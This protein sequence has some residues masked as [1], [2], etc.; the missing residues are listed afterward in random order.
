MVV[1]EGITDICLFQSSFVKVV[2]TPVDE[3][4]Y[5]YETAM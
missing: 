3:S 5:I 4:K 2:S 1:S